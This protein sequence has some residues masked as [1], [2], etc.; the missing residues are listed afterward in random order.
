MRVQLLNALSEKKS[1][2]MDPSWN[3]W[4]SQ[5]KSGNINVLQWSAQVSQWIDFIQTLQQTYTD[6]IENQYQ[7]QMLQI[8]E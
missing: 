7:L 2:T 6:C 5:W 3:N 4:Q 1:N 8:H